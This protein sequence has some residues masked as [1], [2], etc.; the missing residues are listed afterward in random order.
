M[1]SAFQ[2]SR[3][4][5]TFSDVRICVCCMLLLANGECCADDCGTADRLAAYE[6]SGTD[7]RTHHIT[8]GRVTDEC[9]HNL[10]DEKGSEAHTYECEQYGFSWSSCD[11]CGS[12]L[13]GDRYAA[14]VWPIHDERN[15]EMINSPLFTIN[16]TPWG[17]LHSVDQAKSR[18]SQAG[19]YFFSPDTMRFFGSRV[20]DIAYPV[21]RTGG[22][23]IVTSERQDD[24]HPRLYSV[25]YVAPDGTTHRAC[26]FQQYTSAGGAHGAAR[27]LMAAAE[28][29]TY[30]R[31]PH[32]VPRLLSPD[33]EDYRTHW[34]VIEIGERQA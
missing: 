24:Q 11:T 15:T 30:D 21:R 32:D 12:G 4:E 6:T 18:N 31:S 20:S 28:T 23:Y 5:Q 34:G 3:R 19:L 2:R 1:E 27:R 7:A 9:G 14:T 13:G 8:L 33:S 25:V 26:E 17:P 16:G 29:L 22:L 10:Q